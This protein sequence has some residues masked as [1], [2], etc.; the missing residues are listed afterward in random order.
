MVAP[1]GCT[2]QTA[3]GTVLNALR[4]EAGTSIAIFGTGGVGLVAVTGAQVAGCTTRP[5]APQVLA[6]AGCCTCRGG[7]ARGA[8]WRARKKRGGGGGRVPGSPPRSLSAPLGG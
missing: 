3:A 1:S 6:Q 7:T 4:P 2:I 5:G 8:E